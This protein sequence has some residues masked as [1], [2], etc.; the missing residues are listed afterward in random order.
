MPIVVNATAGDSAANSYATVAAADAYME[1]VPAFS[2]TWAA[3]SADAKAARVISGTRALDR[4]PLTGTKAS[5]TQALAFPRASQDDTSIIPPE[6]VEA[7]YELIVYLHFQVDATTG[8]GTR[9]VEEVEVDGVVRLK[10][11]AAIGGGLPGQ[12]AA[13]GGSMDAV[14]ALLRDWLE[15]STGSSF[16]VTK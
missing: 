13:V 1:T 10:Y 16:D 15:V 2:A 8:R 5:A 7:L 4:L 11:G 14:F 9:D 3:F 12:E 6:V